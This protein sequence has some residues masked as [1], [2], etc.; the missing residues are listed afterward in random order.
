MNLKQ[1]VFSIERNLRELL[2]EVRFSEISETAIVEIG[3]YDRT[4]SLYLPDARHDVIQRQILL[5]NDFYEIRLLKMAQ[6]ELD[7]GDATILDCGANIGNHAVFFSTFLTSGRVEAFEF[8]PRIF[9]ILTVNAGLNDFTDIQP[10]KAALGID[11][12]ELEVVRFGRHNLGG[13]ML[14]PKQS[15]APR[16]RATWVSQSIDSFGFRNVGF[17][18]IDVEGLQLPVLKGAADLISEQRPAIWV[19]VNPGDADIAPLMKKFGYDEPMALDDTNF[20]YRR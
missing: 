10:H 4:I 5:T 11:G 7:L 15:G 16:D 12:R 13:T 9:D 3:W 1:A 20:L 8:A 2:A 19:E 14:R 17:I 6:A 18:K